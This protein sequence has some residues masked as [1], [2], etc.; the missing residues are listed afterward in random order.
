MP[1]RNCCRELD[2]A[3]CEVQMRSPVWQ[4]YFVKIERYTQTGDFSKHF[5]C[6]LGAREN[7]SAPLLSHSPNKRCNFR[8]NHCECST[9]HRKSLS[10]LLIASSPFP[11][12]ASLFFFFAFLSCFSL[13][14]Q[15]WGTGDM[16]GWAICVKIRCAPSVAVGLGRFS[17]LDTNTHS[18]NGLKQV[19]LFFLLLPRTH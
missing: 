9:C 15:Q 12:L 14:V 18:N 8:N 11:P 16:K 5:Q 19:L 2:R 13:W 1:A 10:D 7:M 17:F 6:Y 4:N 3:L